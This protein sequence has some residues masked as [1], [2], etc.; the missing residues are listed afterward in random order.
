MGEGPPD[1]DSLPD[2]DL[3]P[4]ASGVKSIQIRL[5]LADLYIERD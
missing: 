2:L 3:T 5:E 1:L 4:S